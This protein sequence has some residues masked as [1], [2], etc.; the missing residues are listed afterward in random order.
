MNV[1]HKPLEA[2]HSL[3]TD[4]HQR[5]LWLW[6]IYIGL[7]CYTLVLILLGLISAFAPSTS[8]QLDFLRTAYWLFAWPLPLAFIVAVVL[9]SRWLVSLL[10]VPL[11]AFMV[12]N[13]PYLL[14]KSIPVP[15]NSTEIKVLTFN[16][17]AR[18]VHKI[19]AGSDLLASSG[20]DIIALQEFGIS[21]AEYLDGF[22]AEHYPYQ[23]LDSQPG[24]FNYVRGQ[25]VF[26]RFPIL[27]SEYWQ[28]TNLPESHGNQRV[29]LSI[30]GQS[31]VFYNI[32]P[33][34]PFDFNGLHIG[35]QEKDAIANRGAIEDIV[36]R[37]QAETDPVIVVG[38]FNTGDQF[39]SYGLFTSILHDSYRESGQG[40]GY[41]YPSCGIGPLPAL[42][43]LDY[44]LF[45]D[46]IVANHATVL[47]SCGI[48]DHKTTMATLSLPAKP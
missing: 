22:L 3:P 46:P 14:P 39:A 25:G 41:S 5:P 34:P 8:I 35:F 33:W 42:I 4:K 28:Y 32:H 24:R 45:S 7:A 20:A 47:D 19:V 36:Q 9:R 15:D 37:T 21:A 17:L 43:R 16:F 10:I 30:D 31:V 11:I 48:S 27:E 38:D 18:D 1:F 29:V 2:E 6:P 23:A 26:S 40:M 12:Y 44:I 13:L